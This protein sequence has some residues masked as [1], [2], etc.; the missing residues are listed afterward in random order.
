MS[1]AAPQRPNSKLPTE[2]TLWKRYSPSGEFPLA[3]ITSLVL[4]TV[5]VLAIVVCSLLAMELFNDDASKPPKM[6]LVEIEGEGGGGL[7]GI[8]VGPGKLDKGP[9]GRTEGAPDAQGAGKSVQGD[10][11]APSIGDLNLKVPINDLKMPG[12]VPD[13]PIVEDGDV[14][15]RLDRER[16]QGEK[17]LQSSGDVTPGKDKD[18][19]GFKGGE[20]DGQPGGAGGKKGPGLGSG[21]GAGKGNSPT[22]VI[23]TDQRRRELRWKIL[24]SDDGDVHLKKLQALRVILMVPLRSKPGM[25]LRY[26]LSGPTL[27]PMEV[28]AAD[29]NNKVRWKNDNQAEMVALQKVLRLKET[30]PFTVI[31]LPSDLEADMAKRELAYKGLQENQIQQTVWDVR[32]RDGVYDNEPTIVAQDVR[33]AGK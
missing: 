18:R 25:A 24:A 13:G 5:V 23:F 27:V 14:W 20:K 16:V 12:E 1:T 3:S 31:Y 6:D 10:K 15:V 26:D 17:I 22:G 21:K 30:P 19:P 28:K 33:A 2:P 8:A 11:P 7:G 32:Q 9:P 4:H 29:D